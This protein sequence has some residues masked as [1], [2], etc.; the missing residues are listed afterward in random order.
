[1]Q[2]L[3]LILL[4]HSQGGALVPHL[5]KFHESVKG[6]ISLAPPARDAFNFLIDQYE[7]LSKLKNAHT[8][9]YK[10]QYET[11]KNLREPKHN[12]TVTEFL[13]ISK[14]Y[15][16]DW[17]YTIQRAP[18]AIK[19]LKKPALVI[20]FENDYQVTAKDFI[21]YKRVLKNSRMSECVWMEKVNHMLFFCK[22]K[23]YQT[24]FEKNSVYQPL[25]K[26]ISHWIDT[27][28]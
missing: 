8:H 7:H 20:G 5:A 15:W 3:P 24:Y 26:K 18:K 4:G 13:G 1:M 9:T 27:Q 10:H 22:D 16:N 23:S 17:S 6:I 12:K 14:I 28:I 21:I 11:Y 25:L 19:D 2:N